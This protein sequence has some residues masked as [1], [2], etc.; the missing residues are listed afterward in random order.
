FRPDPRV[1]HGASRRVYRGPQYDRGHLAPNYAMAQLY[2]RSAQRAAFY[3]SNIAPQ[4]QRLNQLDWQRLEEI[5]IDK[6]APRLG[7]LWI[8]V[9][10]IYASEDSAV[11]VAFFR[12]WQDRTAAGRW[13]FMA[14]RVP[15]DVRGDER[16]SRYLVSVDEVER[17]TGVDFFS[18][19]PDVREQSLEAV[20]ANARR[21]GFAAYACMPAR[22]RD[23]W[24]DRDGIRLQFDRCE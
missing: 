8:T 24:R 2:G 18:G 19:L 11:P 6:M 10:P 20:V 1:A 4:T 5:E 15:Q 9:G 22:Y 7:E 14:F 23:G 17:A 12:I 13:R 3:F 16:L 21:W